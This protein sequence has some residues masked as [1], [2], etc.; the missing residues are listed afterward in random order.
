MS[1]HFLL[2]FALF[3]DT[4]HIILIK[5]GV[6]FFLLATFPSFLPSDFKVPSFLESNPR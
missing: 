6:F 5:S 1:N 3:I 2:E 4:H